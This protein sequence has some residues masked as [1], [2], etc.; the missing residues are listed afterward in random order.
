V[1]NKQRTKAYSIFHDVE[2]TIGGIVTRC[3]FFV[4]ENLSQDIILGRRWERLVRAK[5]DNR[6]DGSCYTTI[7]DEGGNLVTFCSVPAHHEL[8]WSEARLTK[9]YRKLEGKD[10]KEGRSHCTHNGKEKG[11][12]SDA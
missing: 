10:K 3:R 11:Y 9:V 4:L 1:A 5:H 12:T 2:V 7:Y 8:N 6:D